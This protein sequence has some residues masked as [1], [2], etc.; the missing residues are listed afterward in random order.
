MI[1]VDEQSET[2]GMLMELSAGVGGQEAMLFCKELSEM[3]LSYCNNQGWDHDVIQSEKTDLEGMRHTS[4]S[5]D[6]PGILFLLTIWLI[7][8]LIYVVIINID[9]YQKLKFESGVHRVQRVPK[10]EKA[11]RIH[12]STVSVA[13]LPKPTEVT[14][15]IDPKVILLLVNVF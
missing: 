15:T 14:V 11:G 12:T 2:E 9:A 13:I 1:L 5:I 4:I 3:Y 6:H 10:T 8:Y 7:F